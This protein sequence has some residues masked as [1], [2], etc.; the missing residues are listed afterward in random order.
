LSDKILSTEISSVK[1]KTERRNEIKF[2][3][4][5]GDYG[6]FP[7]VSVKPNE[8]ADHYSRAGR[9]RRRRR[10]GREAIN[11]ERIREHK[12]PNY[13][14]RKLPNEVYNINPGLSARGSTYAR[15]YSIVY[16]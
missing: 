3:R 15:V 9:R 14:R 4:A 12:T 2:N 10:R 1:R 13:E 16:V 8:R 11:V 6:L 5:R 7:K